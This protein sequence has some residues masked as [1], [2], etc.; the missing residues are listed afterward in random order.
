[1][2]HYVLPMAPTQRTCNCDM[3]IL[4]SLIL[5]RPLEGQGAERPRMRAKIY[6]GG[7]M[8]HSSMDIGR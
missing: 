6:G 3:E 2:H 7:Q 8:F 5:V 4:R 1:M